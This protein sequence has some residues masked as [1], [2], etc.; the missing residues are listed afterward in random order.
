MP[1]RDTLLTLVVAGMWGTNNIAAKVIMLQVPALMSAGIRFV[2]AALILMPWLRV[3]RADLKKIL[4]I[5]IISGPFHFGFLYNGFSQSHHVGALSVVTLLW[6]PLTTLLAFIVLGEK[7][8]QRQIFGLLLAFGG[9]VVMGF[10]PE[11]F[12]EHTAFLLCFC[13]SLCWG[14]AVVLTRRAGNLSGIS[15]QAWMALITGPGLI[16]AS[17]IAGEK[18]LPQVIQAGALFWLLTLYGSVGSSLFGNILMFNLVRRNPVAKVT[19]LL[20][21]TPIVSMIAGLLFLHETISYQEIV[22]AALTL[23]GAFVVTGGGQAKV[24]RLA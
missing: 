12:K 17:V 1:L 21:L 10:Q 4:P 15:I 7:P 24:A 2:I 5:A 23:L 19:P 20:L 14:I 22:G 16:A 18:A 6:V 9:V 11:L 8:G 13:A 3:S